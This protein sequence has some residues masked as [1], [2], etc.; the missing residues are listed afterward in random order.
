MSSSRD[1]EGK[2]AV[3]TTSDQT[4][5]RVTGRGK[6][7][8]NT[9]NVVAFGVAVKH[10]IQYNTIQLYCLCVDTFAFW[11]VIYIKTFNKINNKTSTTQQLVSTVSSGH[12]KEREMER[13]S[14]KRNSVSET[15]SHFNSGFTRSQKF[16]R[17]KGRQKDELKQA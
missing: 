11:L 12:N 6:N 3:P 15:C 4:V 8:N 17:T 7:H 14:N 2:L 9:C 13:R 5:S 16:E 10:N 1:P